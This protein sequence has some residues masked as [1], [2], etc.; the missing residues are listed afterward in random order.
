MS[1]YIYNYYQLL[2]TDFWQVTNLTHSSF[3]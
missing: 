1:I 3:V 2:A